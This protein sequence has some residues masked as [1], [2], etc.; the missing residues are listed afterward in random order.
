MSILRWL[1]ILA[2]AIAAYHTPRSNPKE[3]TPRRDSVRGARAV[4]T[5]VNS[6]STEHF[7]SESPTWPIAILRTRLRW[8]S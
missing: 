3:G 6:A 5:E 2:G 4:S 8:L 7:P 1:G